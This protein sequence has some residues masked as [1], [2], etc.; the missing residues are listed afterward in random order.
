M[1]FAHGRYRKGA[2]AS[3]RRHGRI[4]DAR[5]ARGRE[6]GRS[7][8]TQ[9][10]QERE[11]LR[12]LRGV[13]QRKDTVP[14]GS[15]EPGASE[16]VSRPTV[17]KV[18]RSGGGVAEGNLTTVPVGSA[19]GPGVAGG[20]LARVSRPRRAMPMVH[21]IGGERGLLGRAGRQPSVT[22]E[23]LTA[24]R[25][26][27]NTPFRGPPSAEIPPFMTPPVQ[28]YPASA[29]HGGIYAAVFAPPERAMPHGAG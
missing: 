12:V 1:G 2:E 9:Q 21:P 17:S 11:T 24:R 14:N 23:G 6:R 29:P 26:C 18:W 16:G 20:Y 25:R 27:R 28:K 4:A 10:R 7:R 19:P 5:G 3:N 8:L 22:V 13:S 15:P